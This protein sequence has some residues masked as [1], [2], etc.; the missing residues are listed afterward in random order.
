[1]KVFLNYCDCAR[2]F[3]IDEVSVNAHQMST[4]RNYIIDSNKNTVIS[5]E[6]NH[7]I[8]LIDEIM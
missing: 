3:D 5:F 4:I 1:M 2:P 6:C 7:R 8:K